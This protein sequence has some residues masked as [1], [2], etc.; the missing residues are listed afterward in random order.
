MKK[1]LKKYISLS[2]PIK[3]TL[4]YT[5]ITISNSMI[6]LIVISIFTRILPPEDF[7]KLNVFNSWLLI[8]TILGSLNLHGGMFNKKMSENVENR[9][10]FYSSMIGLSLA[11]GIIFSITFFLIISLNIPSTA[12]PLVLEP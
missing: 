7:G 8:I 10:N 5:S 9:D 2:H 3:A 6:S 4:W 11:Y 12:H 1:I